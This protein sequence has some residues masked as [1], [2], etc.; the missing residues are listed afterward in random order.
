[1]QKV[2]KKQNYHPDT[3]CIAT[4]PVH[5]EKTREKE[6]GSAAEETVPDM[7][8]ARAC[9]SRGVPADSDVQSQVR[10]DGS[11]SGRGLVQQKDD[12]YRKIQKRGNC[13]PR[14]CQRDREKKSHQN[15]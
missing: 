6:S 2:L 3:Q 4:D 14:A 7:R 9:L 12:T 11:A 10:K 8:E 1:M 5:N 15:T 13:S